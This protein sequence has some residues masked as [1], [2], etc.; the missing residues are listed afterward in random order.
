MRPFL[1]WPGGKQRDLP[2]IRPLLPKSLLAPD[3]TYYEPFFGSGALYFD[4]GPPRAV[5]SDINTRLINTYQQVQ[6]DPMEVQTKL[7]LL[8]RAAEE[9]PKA[10]YYETRD[11]MNMGEGTTG[12]EAAM[13]IYLLRTTFNGLYRENK[14]GDMNA[15]Y[16]SR[17]FS[18]PR[19]V[20]L[21]DVREF[22]IQRQVMFVAGDYYYVAQNAR[23]GD[24]VYFD[25]PY[26]PSKDSKFS[27]YASDGFTDQDHYRLANLA[28]DLS[29]RGVFVAVSNSDCPEIRY[30]YDGWWFEEI[31]VARSIGASAESR[32]KVSDVFITSYPTVG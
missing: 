22:L 31:E 9:D 32:T 20:S 29:T 7:D 4:W 1:K 8:V 28:H 10:H 12:H 26:Y 17:E 5:L 23:P 2:Q 14:S 25:P 30:I 27:S 13:F 3:Y 18:M 19:D 16:G 6:L 15:P 11:L 21:L 24:F